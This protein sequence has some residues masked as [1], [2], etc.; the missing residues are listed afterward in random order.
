MA[1]KE[2]KKE[3]NTNITEA[4]KSVIQS[5]SA[6]F[7]NAIAENFEQSFGGKVVFSEKERQLGRN[8]FSH[9]TQSLNTQ[10]LRRLESSSGNNI[11]PYNWGN[12]DMEDL[13][14]AAYSIIRLGVDA[15]TD[16]HVY[17]IP[18]F[19]R[20]KGKYI[21]NLRL[22]YKGKMNYKIRFSKPAIQKYKIELIY[23]TDKFS[24]TK[25]GDYETYSL[26]ITNPFN[27][28]KII[29]GFGYLLSDIDSRVVL[30]SL[31]DM[32]KRKK[33]AKGGTF[34]N[35]WTEEMYYKTLV[36]Y[37]SNQIRVD[38]DKIQEY[39]AEIEYVENDTK[40][41]IDI[42]SEVNASI[43]SDDQELLPFEPDEEDIQDE[44]IVL[45]EDDAYVNQ[46]GV[47]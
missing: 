41:T 7:T 16:D 10:E 29:G 31:E 46:D 9:I 21:V 22:G 42:T 17:I 38:P 44:N 11:A 27:R 26:E 25:E 19:N 1:K 40:E 33:K 35:E 32:D 5:A 47:N 34:W 6:R 39:R 24:V 37:V 45:D 2:V 4:T 18:Y 43:N 14:I 3:Q 23:S 36:H 13:S 30:M 28:G 15:M 8:L 20:V 12:I